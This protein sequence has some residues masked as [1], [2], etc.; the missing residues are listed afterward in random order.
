MNIKKEALNAYSCSFILMD[1]SPFF[2][3]NI[4]T[5]AFNI[6]YCSLEKYIIKSKR[7][8]VLKTSIF[9]VFWM[10]FSYTNL[11]QNTSDLFQ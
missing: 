10:V 7:S 2:Y 3:E 11:L 5:M 4:L 1:Y 8:K 6:Y 9:V